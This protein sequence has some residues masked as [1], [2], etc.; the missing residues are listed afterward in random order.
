MRLL[1]IALIITVAGIFGSL[2]M[3]G[4]STNAETYV[5]SLDRKARHLNLYTEARKIGILVSAGRKAVTIRATPEEVRKAGEGVIV[6]R[7]IQYKK[8]LS[9][10]QEP[11]RPRPP[12]PPPPPG[13]PDTQTID[14]GIRR[15]SA[16]PAQKINDGRSITV[17]VLDTGVDRNHPDLNVADG[18]NFTSADR[19]DYQDRDGHGTHTSGL[20]AAV[21]NTYGVVGASQARLI[22]GKVLDDGGIGWNSWIADGIEWCADQGAPIISMSLGGPDYSRVLDNA[23]QYA[24]SKGSEVFAAAGNESSPDV[25]FPAGFAGV[26]SISATDEYDELA[27]FSNFGKIEFACP[28][29]SIF[30]TVPG[31][32]ERMSGTSMATPICAGIAALYKAR[33]LPYKAEPIGSAA[34]FG[35]GLLSAKG[36]LE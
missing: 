36:L 33:G 11:P 8:S 35:A 23:V 6:E 9:G 24:L 4:Q 28:G 7:L 21:N 32:Y 2:G 22:V 29:V 26:F 13:T 30:S 15:V 16:V 3:S 14:W 20:V 10:C 1:A 12:L 18:M 34:Q 31:G 19:S 17:C 27:W 25:G 5:V